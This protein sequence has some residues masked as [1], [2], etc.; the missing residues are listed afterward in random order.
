MATTDL[1]ASEPETAPPLVAPRGRWEHFPHD[2]DIGIRGIGPTKSDAFAQA[3]LALAAVIADPATVRPAV[4]VPIACAA[5]NDELLL[6]DWLNAIVFEMATRRMLFRDF[7]VELRPGGLT[8][9][10]R[11]EP[12]DRARHEPAVEIKGATLAELHVG[13]GADGQWSAQCIV[14]V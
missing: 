7:A 12:V 4:T 11:G 10:A 3:A 8:G 14:D 13:P 2:A 5:P 6:I 9:R 1:R